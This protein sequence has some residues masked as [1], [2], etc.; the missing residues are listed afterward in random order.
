MTPE[1]RN[2]TLAD[3]AHLLI[4]AGY[5]FE[6]VE[7]V[8]G[9]PDLW[10][11]KKQDG[12]RGASFARDI[13]QSLEVLAQRCDADVVG[14]VFLLAARR[15]PCRTG[16]SPT[17]K[18]NSHR[19]RESS[20]KCWA[21]SPWR[22]MPRAAP[23]FLLALA[24]RFSEALRTARETA[25]LHSSNWRASRSKLRM[26]RRRQSSSI[27][28]SSTRARRRT[29]DIETGISSRCFGRS[30]GTGKSGQPAIWRF[31]FHPETNFTSTNSS[32]IDCTCD[33]SPL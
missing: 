11:V 16:I 28:L 32:K 13:D 6:L 7:L 5:L 25:R 1:R 3:I 4:A 2:R 17:R 23:R 19:A 9:G 20:V 8:T 29:K 30:W 33:G 24:E 27:W 31:T 22:A 26:L 12:E 15:R 21:P 10:A 18:W 14:G